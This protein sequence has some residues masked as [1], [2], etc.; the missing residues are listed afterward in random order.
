VAPGKRGA[1]AIAQGYDGQQVELDGT[2]VYHEAQ[3][4]IE[5]VPTSLRPLEKPE[6]ASISSSEELG[7]HTLVGEIVDSKCYLGVMKP[8]HL[9]PHRSCAI[10]CISGGVPPVLLVRD[11]NGLAEYFLL[12]G[13]D[14]R[15]LNQEI[16]PLVAEP[17]EVTGQVERHDNLL[18]L[19]ADPATYRRVTAS[20]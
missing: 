13:A 3:T 20:R 16:L 8:G 14:G 17:I 4:M 15:T 6:R 10:R 12:T 7:I 1:K 18:V 19:K 11:E 9:K 2:L 5:V